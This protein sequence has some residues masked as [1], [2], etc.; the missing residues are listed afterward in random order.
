MPQSLKYEAVALRVAL[1]HIA[2]ISGITTWVGYQ[3]IAHIA[4]MNVV[5]FNMGTLCFFFYKSRIF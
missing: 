5:F 1:L 4:G 3:F 2:T